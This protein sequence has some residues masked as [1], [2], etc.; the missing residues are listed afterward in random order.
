MEYHSEKPRQSLVGRD[1]RYLFA[2]LGNR[3]IEGSSLRSRRKQIIGIREPDI[4]RSRQRIRI[5]A[6]D[7]QR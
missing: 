2:L 6:I 7:L 5:V 3:R 1:L 4:L